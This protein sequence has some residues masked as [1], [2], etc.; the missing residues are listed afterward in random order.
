MAGQTWQCTPLTGF[1]TGE[2]I[3]HAERW[4]RRRLS[5]LSALCNQEDL[6]SDP[7]IRKLSASMRACNSS[8]E[9]PEGAAPRGGEADGHPEPWQITAAFPNNHKQVRDIW[10]RGARTVPHPPV[11]VK[12]DL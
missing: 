4:W 1:Q 10:P 5:E 9:R 3:G 12:T 11:S 6:V 7:Y 8:A 2:H